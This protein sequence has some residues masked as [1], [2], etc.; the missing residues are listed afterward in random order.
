MN[1]VI[2][3]KIFMDYVLNKN[4]IYNSVVYAFTHKNIFRGKYEICIRVRRIV[5][6]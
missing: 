5:P 1:N 6:T 4:N 3:K 2:K